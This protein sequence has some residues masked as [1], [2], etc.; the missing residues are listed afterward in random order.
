[1]STLSEAESKRRVAQFGVPVVP[2]AVCADAE[3][4][5]TAA[6]ELGFPVAVKLT[7]PGL[8]HKSE[9]GLVRLALGDRDAVRV[10]ASEILAA[11]LPSD[12]TPALLVAPMLEGARELIAG[13]HTDP[14]F[15]PCVMVGL[16]GILAE[17]IGEV[18]FRL[19][20]IGARDAEEMIEDL[21]A[22]RLLDTVRGEPPVDRDALGAVL[23][24]LS[25]L[26]D[27]DG[28]VVAVDLNPLIV[29]DGRP[30]AVDALV[31]L[32]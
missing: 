3:A 15:G 13:A 30:I 6:E 29:V 16:G 32:R 11:S 18:A 5:V 22:A 21:D 1:M 27:T 12:G 7:A 17:A 9:R 14:H 8:A 20:P 28:D 26:V 10:A 19:V 31:E 24:G 4:A 23:L 25:A 2:D